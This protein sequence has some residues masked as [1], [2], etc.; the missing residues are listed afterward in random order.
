[1]IY[2]P[3]CGFPGEFESYLN[4]LCVY[5]H[6]HYAGFVLQ[7]LATVSI[8]ILV[9]AEDGIKKKIDIDTNYS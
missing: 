6:N 3:N 4:S 8:P 1:M 9:N 7:N 5:N 2:K